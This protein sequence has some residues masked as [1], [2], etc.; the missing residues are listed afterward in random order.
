TKKQKYGR[1][2]TSRLHVC[3]T[4]H[5]A[6]EVEN[7]TLREGNYVDENPRKKEKRG[8]EEIIGVEH[9]KR[10]PWAGCLSLMLTYLILFYKLLEKMMATSKLLW[11]CCQNDSFHGYW[12]LANVFAK[13]GHSMWLKVKKKFSIKDSTTTLL[14]LKAFVTDI[15][16]CLYRFWEAHLHYYYYYKECGDTLGERINIP[17]ADFPIESWKACC[18]KLDDEKFKRWNT[19]WKECF[20]F[21]STETND[22]VL[23]TLDVVWRAKHTTLNGEGVLECV[24][25]GRSKDIHEKELEGNESRLQTKEEMQL[26][27]LGHKSGYTRGKG[28]GYRGSAI[29]ILQEE[30]KKIIQNQLNQI[31]ILQNLLEANRKDIDDYK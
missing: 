30:Q 6:H 19:F 22:N 13:H 1:N 15:M 8:K 31:S 12:E 16:Q 18:A 26:P 23:P 20:K 24:N 2:F 17:P 14:R 9:L 5:E 11:L 10:R 29:A 28:I 21:F 7:P 3:L 27:I 25:D 4:A